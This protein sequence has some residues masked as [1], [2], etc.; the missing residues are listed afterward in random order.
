MPPSDG[1]RPFAFERSFFAVIALAGM[2]PLAMLSAVPFAFAQSSTLW[3]G[4]VMLAGVAAWLVLLTR[5]AWKHWRMLRRVRQLDG[6]ACPNCVYDLR[7]FAGD[8]CPECG[9]LATKADAREQWARVM[10]GDHLTD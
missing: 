9:V 3:I 8:R 10:G 5:C 4:W 1:I 6:A 2:A 7:H